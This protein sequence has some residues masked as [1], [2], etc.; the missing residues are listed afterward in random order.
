MFHSIDS[1]SKEMDAPVK[2]KYDSSRRQAQARAT[3][4][5]IA[6]AARDLFV[7]RGYAGTSVRDIADAAGV[8][9][10]TVYNAFER[11]KPA[12]L[13]RVFEI[14]VVGDDK[15]VALADRTDVRAVQAATH[16]RDVV[17]GWANYV[18]AIS[19]RLLVVYAV[20]LEAAN[21]EPE[22]D[23]LW[24]ANY[25]ENRWHGTRAVAA[26]LK[27]LKA[28]PRGITVD[29][30]TDLMFAYA[31]VHTAAMLMGERGWSRDEYAQWT[32]ETFCRLFEID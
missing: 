20:A 28:L 25:I 31:G 29:R 8:A 22:I 18:A 1:Y 9:V 32:A 19:E 13:A 23:A 3:Q 6:E 11:G 5:Q 26:H 24:R 15:P 30:A 4:G 16:P 17:R 14:A 12:I 21:T 27:Q 2:R 10:Q 7:A